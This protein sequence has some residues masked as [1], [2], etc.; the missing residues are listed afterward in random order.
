MKP[1]ILKLKLWDDARTNRSSIKGVDE[2]H[3][4]VAS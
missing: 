3:W 4:F 2:R 1:E